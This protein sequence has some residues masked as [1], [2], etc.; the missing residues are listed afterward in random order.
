MISSTLNVAFLGGDAE[1]AIV[2]LKDVVA[3]SNGAA[4]SRRRLAPLRGT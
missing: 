3:I 4:S 1:A 2:C